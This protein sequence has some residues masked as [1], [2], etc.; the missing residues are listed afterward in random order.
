MDENWEQV[1]VLD[2]PELGKEE[3][4]QL[5]DRGLKEFYLRPRQMF[6]MAL[7]LR[8]ADDL[9]RKLYGFMSFSGYFSSGNSKKA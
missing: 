3:I 1:T 7:N 9:R 2:Y 5:I 8:S 6:R 4:D